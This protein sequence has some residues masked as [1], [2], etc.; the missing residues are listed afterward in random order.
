MEFFFVII[1]IIRVVSVQNIFSLVRLLITVR[2]WFVK[3]VHEAQ[4]SLNVPTATLMTTWIQVVQ[5]VAA[6]AEGL[7][8]GCE[9][10]ERDIGN[11][12]IRIPR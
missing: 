12:N 5:G 11:E 4:N 10:N 8:A 2:T 9:K 7:N 6:L 3:D 1:V